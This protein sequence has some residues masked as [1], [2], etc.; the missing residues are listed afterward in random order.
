MKKLRKLILPAFLFL[1]L[2]LGGA[3]AGGYLANLA[4]Q[5]LGTGLICWAMLI[6]RPLPLPPQQ[7]VLAGFMLAAGAII[8]IQLVPLPFS[9]WK[10]LPMRAG[11]AGADIAAGV[12]PSPVFLTLM[13]HETIK[14]AVWMLPA[15]GLAI[16]MLRTRAYHARHLAWVILA[17]MVLSVLLGALQLSL[18]GNTQWYFY[19]E[20]NRGSTVG[21]FANSNHLATLLLVS[22]PCLAA[23]A[24]QAWPRD[25]SRRGAVATLA[26]SIL[27]LA[28]V[29]LFVNTSLAG[30]G[31]AVPVLAAS[32][33]ILAPEG[34]L[35]RAALPLLAPVVA[36]GVM[37]VL[38]T[39]KGQRVLAAGGT[40]SASARETIFA[41]CWAAI[42]DF[43]P[44]GSG[45][46]S[47]AEIYRLYE[48]P[49]NVGPRYVNH[50]HND[51]LELLLETGAPGALVLGGFLIWWGWRAI[52]VWRAD[53]AD[54]LARAA[55]I[56]TATILVHSI[57]DYPLRT[58]AISSIFAL[59]CVLMAGPVSGDQARPARRRD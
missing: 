58:A 20:T 18:G 29:G 27:S 44:A 32:A 42:G 4:L 7:Q 5:L 40:L 15:L 25:P 51:Y 6:R 8:A 53:N 1:C 12:T 31:M 9:I 37:L 16:A 14:S 48:D 30:W 24:R 23:S 56:V 28:V 17:A 13:P 33:M 2:I 26:A 57:V 50:A 35:R 46:G 39:D 49:A 19:G 41:K 34:K 22:I 43:M 36:A 45:L 47:F 59:C 52:K 21:F 11:I 10:A 3:S 55:V 54:P 38:A